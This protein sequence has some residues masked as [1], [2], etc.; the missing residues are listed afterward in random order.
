MALFQVI[1]TDEID[2]AIMNPK[3]CEAFDF[4]EGDLLELYNKD[5]EDRIYCRLYINDQ[6]PDYCI[7]LGEN[8]L[9][10]LGIQ[11]DEFIEVSIFDGKINEI[12]EVTIEFQS[13]DYNYDVIKFDENFRIRIINFLGNYFFNYRTD[14]FWPEENAMLTISFP[15]INN[16]E[17]PFIL[18]TY[19]DKIKMKIKPKGTG[20]PF[21]A[22]LIIDCSGSMKRRDIRFMNMEN[23]IDNLI[24]MYDGETTH[25]INLKNFLLDLKPKLVLVPER[26]M[27]S[28]I[29]ATFVSILL[30]FSQKISRGLGE[31]CGIILYSGKALSFKSKENKDIFDSTD[32]TNIELINELKDKLENPIDLSINQTF[33]SPVFK[34]LRAVIEKFSKISKNPILILFLTDGQPEPRKLDPPEKIKKEVEDLIRFSKSINKQ[35]VIFTLGIGQKDQVDAKLLNTIANIGYGEYHFVKTF[36]ELS[37]WFENLANE[38]SINLLKI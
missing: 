17:P 13:E 23:A 14:L 36:S 30:F 31:K 10:N 15:N 3:D 29:N 4:V 27:I 33:F 5:T 18:S 16:L 28:R 19:I 22:I 21:N 1:R 26:Y 9:N 34:H 37:E 8:L 12:F 38:F 6:V 20:T 7:A 2:K 25:H 35:I 32:F 24:Q 11:I